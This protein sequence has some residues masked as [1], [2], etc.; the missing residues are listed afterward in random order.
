MTFF[1][2]NEDILGYITTFLLSDDLIILRRSCKDM[3]DVFDKLLM[4]LWNSWKLPKEIPDSYHF[5]GKVLKFWDLIFWIRTKSSTSGLYFPNYKCFENSIIYGDYREFRI[6]VDNDFY[7]QKSFQLAANYGRVDMILDKYKDYPLYIPV[8]DSDKMA[9][10]IAENFDKLEHH[11]L[12]IIMSSNNQNLINFRKEI[13]LNPERDVK[14]M[15]S[16][17]KCG[18]ISA[19]CN[20]N[21]PSKGELKHQLDLN[22]KYKDAFRL[23]KTL[24]M[25]G[26]LEGFK[27]VQDAYYSGRFVHVAAGHNIKFVFGTDDVI[28]FVK[29]IPLCSDTK[30]LEYILDNF[31][32]VYKNDDNYNYLLEQIIINNFENKFIFNIL[33]ETYTPTTEDLQKAISNLYIDICLEHITQNNILDM[34]FVSRLDREITPL[35]STC[36]LA[37][38]RL[39]TE[40]L[41]L[42]NIII[43]NDF[44]NKISAI[45]FKNHNNDVKYYFLSYLL[46]HG[47]LDWNNLLS[48]NLQ[49]QD[50]LL[51][52]ELDFKY[53]DNYPEKIPGRWRFRKSF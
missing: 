25:K 1:V 45:V 14:F 29:L 34:V 19:Y 33:L 37:V 10:Y 49:L 4:N 50:I 38:M 51:L 24:T 2:S 9:E 8:N 16:L 17:A 48:R 5:K 46:R 27:F 43:D 44:I 52:R 42:N 53:H 11:V 7:N 23:L 20:K 30:M 47:E 39:I 41:D 15:K 13:N 12:P 28:D 36:N 22:G 26:D 35:I 31:N 6:F 40:L 32:E 3:Y 21:N 18:N